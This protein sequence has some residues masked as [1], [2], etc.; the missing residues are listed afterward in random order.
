MPKGALLHAHLDAMV[1]RRFLLDVSLKLPLVHIRVPTRVTAENLSLVLPEFLALPESECTSAAS[2]TSVDYEPGTWV[3][4]K[5]AREAFEPTL[6]GPAGF[7][8][9]LLGTVTINPAEAYG[10][11]NSVLKVVI[12]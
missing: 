12:L 7:D 4:I 6:G 11:H 1:D 3:N 8:A 10:T 2:L 9:W 5:T